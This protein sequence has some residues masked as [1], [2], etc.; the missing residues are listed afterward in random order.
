MDRIASA[1]LLREAMEELAERLSPAS[2]AANSV[3]K[4]PP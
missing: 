3:L 1:L 2:V 4:P